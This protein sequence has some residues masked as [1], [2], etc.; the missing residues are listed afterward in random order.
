M[1]W[2]T[3]HVRIFEAEL[4]ENFEGASSVFV[5]HPMKPEWE[6]VRAPA[7]LRTFLV[8]DGLRQRDQNGRRAP[9]SLD[10]AHRARTEPRNAHP[11]GSSSDRPRST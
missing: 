4:L 9:F 1:F 2:H 3:R 7:A 6:Y 10:G 5:M 11:K 8:L